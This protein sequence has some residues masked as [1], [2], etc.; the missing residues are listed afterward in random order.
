MGEELWYH[1]NGIDSAKISDLNTAHI[2]EKSY[3]HSQ[4]LFKDYYDFNITIIIFEML[5]VLCRRLRT[6]HKL[7]GLLGFGINYSKE[8]GFYHSTKLPILTDDI[9]NLY[10]ECMH[11]FNRY[12]DKSP[13]RK[14]SISFSNLTENQ[15]RQLNLFENP[16]Q[17]K[18]KIQINLAIDGI[19]NRFGNNS[20]I[21]ASALLSDS[22]LIERNSKN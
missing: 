12:Y 19:K 8:G 22:T 21:P 1:A 4:V 10:R 2:K 20:I 11:I 3:S 18:D 17:I 14:V 7:T 9:N 6:T 5:D 13:I 15:N 16:E